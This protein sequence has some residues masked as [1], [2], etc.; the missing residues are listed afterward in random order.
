MTTTS[1]PVDAF[2]SSLS[3]ENIASLLRAEGPIVSCVLLQAKLPTGAASTESSP[4]ADDN[5]TTTNDEPSSTTDPSTNTTETNTEPKT[6]G[7]VEPNTTEKKDLRTDLIAEISIDTTPKKSMVSQI[8]GGPFTFLGQY[9]E[10]GIV[11]MIRREQD[12][13]DEGEEADLARNPHTL[14]P[15]LHDRTV[16]GDIL[17]MRVAPEE[18]TPVD[19]EPTNTENGAI[20]GSDSANTKQE[21][22]TTDTDDTSNEEDTSTSCGGTKTNDEFFLNY[23]KEE[24]ITFASR[25][26]ILPEEDNDDDKND[27]EI[28]G[29]ENDVQADSDGGEPKGEEEDDD[30][31]IDSDEDADSDDEDCQIGMMNLILGQILKR[32]QEENGRGPDTH[33]L[34]TMRAALCSKLGIDCIPPVDDIESKL[35]TSSQGSKDNEHNDDKTSANQGKRKNTSEEDENE[36]GKRVKFSNKDQ[37]KIIEDISGYTSYNENEDESKEEGEKG[38]AT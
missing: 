30:Y 18:D 38:A 6:E 8:L 31:I 25:T 5:D 34:L 13:T 36:G 29:D 15:P 28:S 17:L 2:T 3:G 12:T 4:P 10:E 24:Y 16:Y 23:T 7:S 9:E 1:E 21:A 11:V 20:V 33:E 22:E 26:D 35:E 14:Q 27:E 19:S 32:F 37:I